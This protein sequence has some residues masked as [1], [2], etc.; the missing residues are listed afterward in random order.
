MK[1]AKLNEKNAIIVS[2]A[3]NYRYFRKNVF[4]LYL[5]PRFTFLDLDYLLFFFSIS[6]IVCYDLLVARITY[7]DLLVVR[8]IYCEFLFFRIICYEFLFTTSI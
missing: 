7:F 4:F 6:L 8:I 3:S 1:F 5:L 2:F